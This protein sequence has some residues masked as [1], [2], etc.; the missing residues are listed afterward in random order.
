MGRCLI[1][2]GNW[3]EVLH[4]RWSELKRYV[5][6]PTQHNTS[7]LAR[8]KNNIVPQLLCLRSWNSTMGI[9]IMFL[10]CFPGT[11]VNCS[12]SLLV[13]CS[14]YPFLFNWVSGVPQSSSVTATDTNSSG[15]ETCSGRESDHTSPQ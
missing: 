11:K 3:G 2:G 14:L 10:V 5:L 13:E 6:L 7:E 4:S 9:I 12:S 15:Q 1:H 8:V